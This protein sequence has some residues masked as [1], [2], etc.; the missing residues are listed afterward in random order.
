[1]NDLVSVFFPSTS[2][3]Q[4]LPYPG[5]NESNITSSNDGIDL[6]LNGNRERR[7]LLTMRSYKTWGSILAYCLQHV[8]NRVVFFQLERAADGFSV[9][10]EYYGRGVF[11][12]VGISM[13][14]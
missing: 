13:L 14:F 10:A 7:L 1:M 5:L 9:V 11:N 8:F 6:L 3:N 12:K 2:F 4:F